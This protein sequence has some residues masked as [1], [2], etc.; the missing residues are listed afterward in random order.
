MSKKFMEINSSTG[1][2]NKKVKSKF[3]MKILNK[4][5]WNE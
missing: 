5:G 1:I 3:G 2:S 4:L